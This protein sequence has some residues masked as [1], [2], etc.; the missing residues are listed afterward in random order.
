MPTAQMIILYDGSRV[1]PYGK[2]KEKVTNPRIEEMYDVEFVVI[3]A[4]NSILSSATVQQMG[5]LTV[6]HE[7]I[8]KIA[9]DKE[10]KPRNKEHTHPMLQ[11]HNIVFEKAVGLLGNDLHLDVDRSVKPVQMSVRRIPVAIKGKL[12]AELDRL[13]KL[14]VLGKIDEP[15]EWVSSLVIVKKPNGSLRLCLNP[16]PLK[17]F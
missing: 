17:Q 5:L 14:G 1:K 12:K 2:C 15:T 16:K 4:Q 11:K 10:V 3:D 6:H 9:T 8:Q 13:E 7:M